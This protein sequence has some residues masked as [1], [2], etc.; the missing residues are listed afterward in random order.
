[1]SSL[2]NRT[3]LRALPLGGVI[4]AALVLTIPLWQH[5]FIWT[6][7]GYLHLL[8]ILELTEQLRHGVF[9]PRWSENLYFG[10][11]Y[12]VFHFYSPL[13]YYVITTFHLLGLTLI[14]ALKLFFALCFPLAAVGMYLFARA[15]FAPL[16]THAWQKETAAVVAAIAYAAAPYFVLDV[17]VRGATAEMLAMALLPF[18]LWALRRTVNTRE[19]SNVALFAL[20][21]ALLILSHNLTTFLAVPFVGGFALLL[22]FFLPTWQARTRAGL[23][24]GVGG[25]VGVGLAAF[26]W[27]PAFFEMPLVYVGQRAFADAPLRERL[28]EHFLSLERLIDFAWFYRFLEAP[29]PLGI[30]GIVLAALGLGAMWHWL[31]RPL[32]LEFVYWGFVV[33]LVTFALTRA[34]EPLWLALP[35]L[36]VIQFPW[37]LTVFWSLGIALSVGLVGVALAR[38]LAKRPALV[39]L[40]ALILILNLLAVS[41]VN[42]AP[43]VWRVSEREQV[44]V[45]M[46]AR[47]EVN[48]SVPGASYFEPPIAEYLPYTVKQAP[49]PTPPPLPPP[50][51]P[52]PPPLLELVSQHNQNWRVNVSSGEAFTLTLRAFYFPDWYGALD[53][54]AAKVFAA[55]EFGVVGVR[56]PAGHHTLTLTQTLSAPALVGVWLTALSGIAFGILGA[57]AFRARE[58]ER[59]L[60]LALF[61]CAVFVFALPLAS[62]AFARPLEMTPTQVTLDEANPSLRVIGYG[63]ELAPQNILTVHLI[64]QVLNPLTRQEPIELRLVNQA[65]SVV[66]RQ[67]RLARYG[68]GA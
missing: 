65:G 19:W 44:S 10:Y 26:Y 58:R 6:A 24:L 41:L 3:W 8:R 36:W 16:V 43:R 48:S 59:F 28:N 49:L 39:W 13:S 64:W 42:L 30:A 47:E 15:T 46:L 40:G 52:S 55:N 37:R 53:G 23:R 25:F 68:G 60:P 66:A 11:G 32:K 62:S 22:L 50:H 51:S 18:L 9:Y 29:W 14:D 63:V 21:L 27:V 12:P 4:A 56:V 67:E 45:G 1:M 61:V 33:A 38:V 5:P 31:K 34:A 54:S 17:Y 57:F 20:L 7:D 2:Q 35:S